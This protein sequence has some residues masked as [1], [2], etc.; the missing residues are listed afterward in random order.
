MKTTITN[1]RFFATALLFG[2]LALISCDKTKNNPGPG[3]VSQEAEQALKSRYPGATN[4]SWQTKGD[5]VVANFSLSAA[6]AAATGDNRS[7]WFDNGGGWYMTETDIPFSALPEAVKTGFRSSEYKDWTV[8]EVDKLEREGVETIYVIEAESIVEGA[9]TEINLYYSPDGV[10]TKKVVDADPEY[11]YG[12]YIPSKPNGSAQDH[13]RTNYP[14]A[15]ILDIDYENGMTEVEI[16]D[17]RTC[18]DLLFDGSGNWLYTKTEIRRG[19]V[20]AAVMQALSASEYASYYID[21][22]DFYETADDNYYRFDLESALGDIKVDITLEGALTVVTADNDH[23]GSGNGQMIDAA[24]AEFIAGKY[25]G[26]SILEYDYDNGLLE[27]EFRH[28]NR[29]KNAYFNGANEWVRTEWDVRNSE[30]PVAVTNAI[31]ASEWATYRLNDIEYTQT[32]SGE[33][34][35]LELEQGEREVKLRIDAQGKVL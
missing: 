9:E 22:I 18:R 2:A 24:V 8:D 5:Y 30:L 21:D 7:A 1:R 10:L 34:Y 28:E 26:A 14:D 35:L 17:G 6:K 32:P 29:E 19:E 4:I 11:D 20:P 13:V 23:S 33:Y 3:A 15:R 31:A 16:L 12:D 25:Q 27:V